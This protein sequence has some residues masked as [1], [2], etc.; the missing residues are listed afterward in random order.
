[1][2]ITLCRMFKKLLQKKKTADKLYKRTMYTWK[3]ALILRHTVVIGNPGTY[4]TINFVK[5][6]TQSQFVSR[7][8]QLS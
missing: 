1:M 3:L 5:T 6:L 7:K 8:S 4:H 2:A